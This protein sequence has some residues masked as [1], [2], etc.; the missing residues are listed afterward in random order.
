M[1]E[2]NTHTLFNFIFVWWVYPVKEKF[3]LD[4]RIEC[5][6][7][8]VISAVY[9]WYALIWAGAAHTMIHKHKI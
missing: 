2:E 4:S 7:G 1:T 5:D 9:V 8:R 6:F 3:L